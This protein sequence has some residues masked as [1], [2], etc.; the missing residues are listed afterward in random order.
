MLIF[1]PERTL[2]CVINPAITTPSLITEVDMPDKGA[3]RS[4]T[5]WTTPASSTWAS[6]PIPSSSQL[7]A[8]EKRALRL[9]ENAD[10]LGAF[11][12][13]TRSKKTWDRAVA[14]TA[15]FLERR[16][17][18]VPRGLKVTFGR[19]PGLERPVPDYEFFTIQLT[20]CR[21]FWVK[22]DGPGFEKVEVCFGIQI[23]PLP[24]PGGPIA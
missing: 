5:T 18:K 23:V 9:S 15:A 16:G 21:S 2:V 7:A 3:Y 12:A 1:Q 8:L 6:A 20:R 13:A 19:V 11:S 14:D 10:F 22:K 4:A 17:V 24:L